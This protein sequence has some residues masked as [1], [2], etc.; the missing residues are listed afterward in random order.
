MLKGIE[1]TV[2]TD[3]GDEIVLEIP[4]RYEVCPRC[5]GHG[6]HVNPNVDGHGLSRED[7]AEDPDFAE[8]YFGGMYDV[9][10]HE[11]RGT[12]VILVPDEGRADADTLARYRRMQDEEAEYRREVMMERRY[13]GEY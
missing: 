7:F 3:D 8:A 5:E 11:C 1:F 6:K 10:C 9:T 12:R 2:V 13:C 4:A